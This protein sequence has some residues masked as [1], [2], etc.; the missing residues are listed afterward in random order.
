[1]ADY[2]EQQQHGQ[3]L[4]RRTAGGAMRKALKCVDAV[5]HV[6]HEGLPAV[7]AGRVQIGSSK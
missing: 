3:A 1:M 2:R 5:D 4:S 7:F 6:L